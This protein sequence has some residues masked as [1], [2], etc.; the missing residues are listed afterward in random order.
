MV[1]RVLGFVTLSFKVE[2]CTGLGFWGVG[3]SGLLFGSSISAG[4]LGKSGSFDA[5][6]F[7]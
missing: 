2:G 3:V 7:R 1:L 4:I 5:I 6:F